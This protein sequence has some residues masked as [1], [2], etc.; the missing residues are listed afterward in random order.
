M[1]ASFYHRKFDLLVVSQSIILFTKD[2]QP[3]SVAQS[4][5]CPTGDQKVL[6]LIPTGSGNILS[7]RLIMIYFLWSFSPFP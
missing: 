6:G 1:Y 5:T 2:F 7:W 4:D 3:A